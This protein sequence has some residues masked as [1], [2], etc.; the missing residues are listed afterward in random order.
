MRR[1]LLFSESEEQSIIDSQL[2]FA[3]HGIPS[4]HNEVTEA[5]KLFDR[6]FPDDQ[7]AKIPFVECCPGRRVMRRFVHR[8]K[9]SLKVCVPEYQEVKIHTTANA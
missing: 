2:H 5:I 7:R 4:T 8:H 9:S 3:D 6:S 1:P